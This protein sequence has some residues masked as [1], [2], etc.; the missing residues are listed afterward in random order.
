MKRT[1]NRLSARQVETLKAPGRHADGGNLYLSI[2]P[3]GARRWMFM[4]ALNGKQREMGLGS[5]GKGEVPLATARARATAARAT[6]AAGI[7]PLT[8]KREAAQ[9]AA[10]AQ[11]P[12]FGKMADDY[13][14]AMKPSWRNATH[15]KQWIYTL[16]ELAAP[17]RSRRVDQIQT[18]DVLEVLQPLWQSVPE[19]ASRLRGRIERI[20]DAAKAKGFR[21]GENPAR[22]RGH[23]ALLLPKRQKLTR[24]HHA[25]LPYDQMPSFMA[26]LREGNSLAAQALEL[27]ILCA[28]RTSEVIGARWDEIDVPKRLWTIPPARMKAGKEHRIPLSD[29]AIAVLRDLAKAKRSNFVFPGNSPKVPLSNMS[30]AMYLRRLNAG[31]ATVHGFRSAFR[32]WASETTAFPHEV[33]EAALAHVIKNKAESAYR[34]GDMLA[35]R[36][37]LMNAWADYCESKAG[38]V[39]PLTRGAKR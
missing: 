14:A 29:R 3:Q 24:G 11:A 6:L 9:R 4:Y 16:E 30:M 19:T 15:A 7:D 23:L 26:N 37:K 12:T 5:A 34:R 27:T 39:V 20:L 36:A 32:D 21:Q 31:K 28:C 25:A 2:S 10:V 18:A 8:A 17:L 38:K 13:V 22:W 33:C 35:K 1:L